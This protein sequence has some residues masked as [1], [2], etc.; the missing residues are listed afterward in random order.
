M[1]NAAGGGASVQFDSRND[2]SRAIVSDLVSLIEHVQASMKLIE[3]AIARETVGSQETAANVVVLD[4]VTP[5]TRRRMAAL[6][7]CN[8]SLGVALHVLLDARTSDMKRAVPA[9]TPPPVLFD[10]PRLRR[11]SIGPLTRA[12]RP[13]ASSIHA[14]SARIRCQCGRA[15]RFGRSGSTLPEFGDPIRRDVFRCRRGSADWRPASFS[16]SCPSGT[17]HRSRCR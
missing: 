5:A 6:N 3:S 2:S 15:A 7:T 11:R 1:Q 10:R 17:E 8:A 16:C 14:V 9:K 13:A 12:S 4:D